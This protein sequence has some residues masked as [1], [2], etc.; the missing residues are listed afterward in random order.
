MCLSTLISLPNINFSTWQLALNSVLSIIF[1][2]F[3]P[4]APVFVF[5]FLRKSKKKLKDKRFKMRFLSMYTALNIK[6]KYFMVVTPLFLVRRLIY[7]LTIVFMNDYPVLQ[8]AINL[9]FSLCYL[10]FLIKHMPMNKKYLNYLEIMNECTL[11]IVF[12]ECM[13]FTEFV[14]EAVTRYNIGWSFVMFTG[15]NLTV[16]LVALIHKLYTKG[17]KTIKEIKEWIQEKRQ[18][19]REWRLKR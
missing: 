13:A 7:A 2:A 16:A 9:N 6:K 12:Y 19:F 3:I 14:S 10:I 17:K 5:F 4:I 18:E 1:F 15:G 8:I 11:M